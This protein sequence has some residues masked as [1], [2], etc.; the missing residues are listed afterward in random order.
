MDLFAWADEQD[1]KR[2]PTGQVIDIRARIDERVHRYLDLLEMTLNERVQN[3]TE[4]GARTPVT[5]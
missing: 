4:C 5:E 1:A 2:V 3:Q